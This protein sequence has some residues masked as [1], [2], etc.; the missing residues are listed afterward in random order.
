M[1]K[2]KLFYIWFSSINN[3]QICLTEY[4]GEFESF[5]KA[6]AYADMSISK[7]LVTD[8]CGNNCISALVWDEKTYTKNNMRKHLVK[9][10][11]D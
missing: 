4:Y 8:D 3:G 2:S 11:A 6:Q 10:L 7:K 9:S 1:K 5:K